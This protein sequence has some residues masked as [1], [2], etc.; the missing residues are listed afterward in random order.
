MKGAFIVKNREDYPSFSGIMTF[1]RSPY[2]DPEDAQAGEYVVIGAPYD[3]T[4]GSRPGARYAP[5]VIRQETV[6]FLYH[7]TAID[8][9]VI[10]VVTKQ[11]MSAER[12]GVIKDAGDVRV[13]N[14]DI[15][16]TTESIAAGVSTIAARGATPVVLGGDHYIA[17]PSVKGFCEGMEKRLGRK[18]K[19][20]FIHIDSHLDAYDQNETWGK[21][22]HGSPTRRISEL[23]AVD[24][25][26]M[27]WVG[28]NGTTGIEP[29]NYITNNGGT[30]LTIAD[31]R[32]EGAKGVMD[33]AAA[34]A[35]DETDAIYVTIDIDVVD[36]AY[37]IGT[38]SYIYGGITAVELLDMTVALAD[39]N[40][41]A[42][43]I[44][45]VSP[46]LDP[47]GNTGRLAA[48]ALLGFLKPR[49]FKY[50]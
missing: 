16:K 20:G 28:I 48:T 34:I 10:D 30:I 11:R 40:I 43:D 36:Q 37:S 17:Y 26:N 22:Y 18:P 33:H 25:K 46:P 1:L 50:Y 13:Y 12:I 7:L 2:I 29:Y 31:V 3:V 19:I 6:H 38:G 42:I 24:M 21:Y 44:V 41:G 32:K 39:K 35:G 47:S 15:M 27:V 14:A 23:E 8:G 4:T 49:L 9:E 45:E 5:N